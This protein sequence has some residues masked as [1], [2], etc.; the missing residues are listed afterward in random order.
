MR[1]RTL[2]VLTEVPAAVRTVIPPG[3]RNNLHWQAG[4]IVTVQASLLYLRSGLPPFLNESYFTAFAKGTS[5]AVWTGEE[6]SYEQILTQLNSSIPLL[7]A[8]ITRFADTR[9]PAPIT[10]STGDTLTSFAE[11]L[12]FLPIHEA[13]HQG[14]IATMVRILGVKS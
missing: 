13:I 14:A 4:H 3:L 12:R 10:A 5:P 11:A 9:Y 6:P 7:A 8:D 2:A 1:Q